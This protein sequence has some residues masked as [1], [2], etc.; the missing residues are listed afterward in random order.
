[1]VAKQ[2]HLLTS[3]TPLASRWLVGSSTLAKN[4]EE[5]RLVTLS[6]ETFGTFVADFCCQKYQKDIF[7]HFYKQNL[8]AGY[9]WPYPPGSRKVEYFMF[10]DC[11]STWRDA[12]WRGATGAPRQIVPH[13]NRD[14]VVCLSRIYGLCPL[15]TNV[16]N[17]DVKESKQPTV[18]AVWTSWCLIGCCVWRKSK[19]S[20]VSA[21]TAGKAISVLKYY[22]YYFILILIDFNQ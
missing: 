2:L 11:L 14:R 16:L 12:A 21:I 20:F 22:Y 10:L 17:W 1:M 3:C 13:K 9:F 4:L 5:S 8:N 19:S 6:K 15:V 7:Y 18:V